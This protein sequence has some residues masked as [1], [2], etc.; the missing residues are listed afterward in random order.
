MK[1]KTVLFVDD[2]SNILNSLKR[3]LRKEDYNILTADSAAEG[4][5]LLEN[6]EIHLVVSDQRMPNMEGTDFLQKV[7]EKYPHIVRVILSGYADVAVIVESINKGEIYRFLGKPWNDEE[8]KISVRQCLEH[9]CILKE[10]SAL[11]EQTRIQNEKLKNLNENLEEIIKERTRVL[12]FSQEILE[13]LPVG[14]VGVSTDMEV[15]LTN[16]AAGEMITTLRNIIP[17]TPIRDV[18]PQEVEN[19]IALCFSG[20]CS[21]GKLTLPWCGKVYRAE[22]TPLGEKSQR[23]CILMLTEGTGS[24]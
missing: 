21:A 12:A 23:G 18:L 11:I 5:E 6:N 14:V 15:I 22:L 10:N 3:L 9:Y 17:G 24:D 4:L 1:D 13:K 2:E 20:K 19:T 7:K 16:D 8:L